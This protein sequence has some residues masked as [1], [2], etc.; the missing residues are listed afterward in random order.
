MQETWPVK[1]S[2]ADEMLLFW[3]AQYTS[4]SGRE[5]T[6][7]NII[8]EKLISALQLVK[9]SSLVTGFYPSRAMYEKVIIIMSVY[10]FK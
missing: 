3:K 6:Y 2:V 4:G 1:T 7:N 8:K 10:K 5:R 9:T